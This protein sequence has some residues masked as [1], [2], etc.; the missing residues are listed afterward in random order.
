MNVPLGAV[1]GEEEGRQARPQ[2]P[3]LGHDW[4]PGARVIQRRAR[5]RCV[6]A[7]HSDVVHVKTYRPPSALRT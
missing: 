7:E 4:P 2:W 5:Q 1:S 6:C 3:L